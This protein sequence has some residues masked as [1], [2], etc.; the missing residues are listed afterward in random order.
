VV[1][2]LPATHGARDSVGADHTRRNPVDQTM[3]LIRKAL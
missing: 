2:R 1:R 3:D